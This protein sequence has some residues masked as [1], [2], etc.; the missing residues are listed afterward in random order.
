MATAYSTELTNLEATPQVM[1]SPGSATGKVRVWSDTIA[2]GTGDIDDNDIL[3]M[4]EIPSNANW[5]IDK[6]SHEH[7][8]QGSPNVRYVPMRISGF[9]FGFFDKSY[10]IKLFKFLFKGDE[11]EVINIYSRPVRCGNIYF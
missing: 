7:V 10:L 8:I 1:V 5:A 3:M 4:A 6:T 2:A 11:K 9:L